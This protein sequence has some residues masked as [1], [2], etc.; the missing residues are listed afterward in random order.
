MDRITVLDNLALAEWHVAIGESLIAEQR[1]RLEGVRE[2][3]LDTLPYESMLT[4][5]E[6]I[7]DLHLADRDRLLQ[8]L[9]EL[10]A[11]EAA[12]GSRSASTDSTHGSRRD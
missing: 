2:K 5:L 12:Q 11:A 8:E 3:C 7:R 9:D 1:A 10:T 6:E 4:Q